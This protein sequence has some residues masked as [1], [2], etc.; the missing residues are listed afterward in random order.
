MLPSQVNRATNDQT[1]TLFYIILQCDMVFI[2]VTFY[3]VV[4]S[5]LTNH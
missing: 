3:L 5:A 2:L 4:Y 1:V